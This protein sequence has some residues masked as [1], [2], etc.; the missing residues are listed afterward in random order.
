[1]KPNSTNILI[2]SMDCT[3]SHG[4]SV[5]SLGQ[6]KEEYDIVRDVYVAN[7]KMKDSSNAA[8]IKVWPNAPSS[9]SADLQGGGGKGEVANVTFDG[10]VLDNC[11]YAIEVTQCYG[12]KNVSLCLEDPSLLTITDIVFKNFQGTTSARYNP[13]IAAFLCSSKDV[14]K[15]ISAVN[16]DVLS[17]AKSNQA[18]CMNMDNTALDVTCTDKL[19]GTN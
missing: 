11:D 8:R 3:G 1:M 6:Y 18:Y 14:C 13:Q 17:P 12:Q 2:E 7:V 15:G 5:G 19:L 16:I 4:M 10:M 9:M